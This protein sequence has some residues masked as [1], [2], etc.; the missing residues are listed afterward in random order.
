[1]TAERVSED[2]E[3]PFRVMACAARGCGASNAV[4]QALIGATGENFEI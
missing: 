3:A 2:A 1:M 4:A